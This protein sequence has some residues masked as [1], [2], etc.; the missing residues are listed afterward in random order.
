[1]PTPADLKNSSGAT[2]AADGSSDQRDEPAMAEHFLEGHGVE[3]SA[4]YHGLL[5]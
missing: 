4:S 2:T 3:S 1:L 5:G